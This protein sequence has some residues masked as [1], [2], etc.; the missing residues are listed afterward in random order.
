MKG[1]C[2]GCGKQFEL[3]LL[4]DEVVVQSHRDSD[5]EICD[6]SHQP[7]VVEIFHDVPC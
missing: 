2:C 5:G 7:P 1:M 4:E 6:G 3:E